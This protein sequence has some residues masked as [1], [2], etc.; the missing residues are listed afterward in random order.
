MILFVH[1]SQCQPGCCWLPSH[2]SMYIPYINWL[3]ERAEVPWQVSH[4]HITVFASHAKSNVFSRNTWRIYPFLELLWESGF[5]EH[6]AKVKSI[7]YTFLFLYRTATQ[8]WPTGCQAA[9]V[10]ASMAICSRK[11]E[12]Q[13]TRIV[14]LGTLIFCSSLLLS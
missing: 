3:Q 5:T 4:P 11:P 2:K 10:P 9:A 7:T 8:S 12:Q 13:T 6:I 14:L 1:F